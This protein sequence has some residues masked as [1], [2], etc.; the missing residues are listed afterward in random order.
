MRA[1]LAV[2]GAAFEVKLNGVG[3]PRRR[4]AAGGWGSGNVIAVEVTAQDGDDLDKRT[5]VTVT[6]AGLS[7]RYV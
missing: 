1:T 5:L 4:C 3:G 2:A 7:G 6:R